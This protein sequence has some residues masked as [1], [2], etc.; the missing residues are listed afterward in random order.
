[1]SQVF[2]ERGKMSDVNDDPF[3]ALLPGLV[4]GDSRQEEEFFGLAY[5]FLRAVVGRFPQI[6]V[7]ERDDFI[8]EVIERALIK[9]DCYSSKRGSFRAWLFI[10]ARNHSYDI[11]RSKQDGRDPLYHAADGGLI[12]FCTPERSSDAVSKQS[13]AISNLS[14]ALSRLSSED[15][16]ILTSSVAGETSALIGARLGMSAANVR[17]RNQRL[18]GRLFDELTKLKVV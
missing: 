16:D 10:I 8:M 18:R 7:S 11:G 14:A 12:E 13:S 6:R 5:R 17:K 9:L 4:N 3:A 1:M 15:Q 2:V